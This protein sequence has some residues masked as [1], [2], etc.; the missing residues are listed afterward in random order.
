M[1]HKIKWPITLVV[2]GIEISF[3]ENDIAFKSFIKR[4]L[5]GLIP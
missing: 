3:G 1:A 4:R 5:Q 2:I